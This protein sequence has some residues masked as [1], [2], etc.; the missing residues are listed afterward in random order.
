MAYPL[1]S[2]FVTAWWW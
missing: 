2:T 1:A